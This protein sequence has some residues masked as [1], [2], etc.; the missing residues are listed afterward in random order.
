MDRARRP[1]FKA[2]ETV[3]GLTVIRL[4]L[5]LL[6]KVRTHIVTKL[7][8][9]AII[10]STTRLASLSSRTCRTSITTRRAWVA[11]PAL[12]LPTLSESPQ[13]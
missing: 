5:H 11:P 8:C 2:K 7:P 9:F 3:L 4:R 12:E 13:A 1:P 10:R 6:S